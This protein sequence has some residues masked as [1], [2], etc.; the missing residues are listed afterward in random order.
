MGFEK[1]FSTVLNAPNEEDIEKIK[2]KIGENED[3]IDKQLQILYQWLDSKPKL[4]KN[5]DR[6]KVLNFLRVCSFDMEKCKRKLQAHFYVR[7]EYPS[8]F[9]N[10]NPRSKEISEFP[11]IGNALF[12][13]NLTPNGERIFF[14][15]L[16]EF[17][18][19]KMDVHA[20]V[21][22]SYMCYDLVLRE[23]FPVSGD[24]II[25]DGSGFTMKHF[26]KCIN[27]AVK[28]SVEIAYKGY[29]VRQK[30]IYV[31]NAPAAVDTMLAT[32]KLF[33]TEKI[34]KRVVVSK[35]YEILTKTFPP[36]CLPEEYGGTLPKVNELTRKWHEVMLNNEEWFQDQ[37]KCK[38]N[39]PPQ[40][41]D[42]IYDDRF[43]VE[44]TFR[45]LTID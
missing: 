4:P 45:K 3:K 27:T 22:Y 11:K 17:D 40:K 16:H 12:L 21:K 24:V 20:Y 31:V 35:N 13:P 14:L 29:L 36:H 41:E 44:G 26:L 33:L 10:L 18:I 32:W 34:R 1:K 30:A 37:E 19:D 25:M 9:S 28:D 43:G 8:V 42:N 6:T 7:H 5:Y 39:E 2:K 15:S 38:T 23:P